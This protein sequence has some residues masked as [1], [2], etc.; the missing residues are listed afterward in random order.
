MIG[1]TLVTSTPLANLMRYPLAGK[2]CNSHL[3]RCSCSSEKFNSEE[4]EAIKDTTVIENI[5]KPAFDMVVHST[6]GYKYVSLFS[7]CPLLPTSWG[8][9]PSPRLYSHIRI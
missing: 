8:L 2:V 1:C 3:P 4:V 9:L 6:R 5:Y 7:L